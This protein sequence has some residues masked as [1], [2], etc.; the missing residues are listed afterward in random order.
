[1]LPDH[2]Q[3][4]FLKEDDL[5]EVLAITLQ[6]NPAYNFQ[7]V[8]SCAIHTLASILDPGPV[9]MSMTLARKGGAREACLPLHKLFLSQRL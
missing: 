8:R 9:R 6:A 1:M 2:G 3:N 7:A 5:V 4:C